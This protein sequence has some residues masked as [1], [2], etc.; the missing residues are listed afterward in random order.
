MKKNVF[1]LLS[2]VLLLAS[3][4]GNDSSAP[5][6][7]D[8][9]AADKKVEEAPAVDPAVTKGMD[10]IAKSDCLTCHKLREASIGP[11]YAAV[12][13]KYKTLDQA[14][15]DSMV[16]Q[17]HKGG[18]GKWGTVPMTPHPTVSREDAEAMVH[19]IMSI[20]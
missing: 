11:S 3:C 6:T 5:E 19:Y 18:S 15:M 7:T 13:A 12:S 17:I 14:A 16:S 8:T 9:T 4:G 20:K 10:L 2:S 1:I